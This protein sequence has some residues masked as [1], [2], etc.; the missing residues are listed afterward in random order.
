MCFSPKPNQLVKIGCRDLQDVFHIG[1]TCI[2]RSNR[3]GAVSQSDLSSAFPKFN[4]GFDLGIKPVDMNRLV[5]LRIR[6][7]SN[8]IEP[9]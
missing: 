7:K 1:A 8:S 5:I 4:N 2:P 6:D 3:V 9:Y